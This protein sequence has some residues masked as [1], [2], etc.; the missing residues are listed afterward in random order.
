MARASAPP[1]APLLIQRL[2]AA[3]SAAALFAV[4]VPGIGPAAAAVDP[5]P[6]STRSHYLTGTS[7][8][9]L[10]RAGARDA[11]DSSTAGIG[12]AL[13]VL[14]AGEPANGS[15][16]RLPG[17][18]RTASYDDIRSA[19]RAYGRSWRRVQDAPHLTLVLM[20][21]AHGPSVDAN[22]GTRWGRLVAQLA[23]DLPGVDVRGGLD[24]EVEWAPASDVR[25]WLDAYLR[26]TTRPFV[27]VGSCTCPPFAR[28]AGGW[29]LRAL[30]DVAWADGRGSVL[31]QIYARAGGNSTEWATL[32][33]WAKRHHRPPVRFV[34]VLT[35]QAACTGPPARPCAGIDL[36][37]V[38]A[39]RQL[40][41]ASGQ[42][43]QWATDIGYLSAP[44]PVHRSA[45]RP[46]LAGL[47][48]LAIAAGAATLGVLAWRSR[49]VPRRRR[50]RRR[51]RR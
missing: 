10:S 32:A 50:P 4:V 3:A 49:W 7:S 36:D 1:G 12:D 39:W 15:S 21:A 29:S 18:G 13:V 41:A 26:A 24:V 31:P 14:G 9:A 45:L 16:L 22:A 34:G 30:A 40:S 38:T 8:S 42:Q 11:R 35:E 51:R 47:V 37:P 2:L 19:A 46:L 28:V 25:T 6:G 48:T 20:A 17:S 27:D 5:F 23:A 43:L 44:G 33:S